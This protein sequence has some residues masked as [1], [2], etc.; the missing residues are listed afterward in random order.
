M[1]FPRIALKRTI[2]ALLACAAVTSTPAIATPAPQ[3]AR[4]VIV[5][6]GDAGGLPTLNAAGI[7]AHDKPQSL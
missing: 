3:H 7:L 2:T 4:N 6:L 5:F 1:T